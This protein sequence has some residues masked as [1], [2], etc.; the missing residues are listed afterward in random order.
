MTIQIIGSADPDRLYCAGSFSKL[1]T[2]FITLSLLSERYDLNQILDDEKFFDAICNNKAS[3][4]FLAIFQKTIGGQF[5]LH[6]IC[7]FYTGLPYTFDPSEEEI[8]NVDAGF[9]Y[10]HHSIRDEKTFL[11]HCQNLITPVYPNRCKF[12]YSEISILFLGYLIEKVYDTS[13]EILYQKYVIEKFQLKHSHFSRKRVNDVFIQDLSEYYDLASIA[14]MDHGYFCYSNG[15]YTTLRDEKILL[16]G[17]LEN[18]VFQFM[19][20]IHI[21]RAA[22][23]RLMNGLT[24]ELRMAQDDVII[25]YDGLSFSGCN[26][27][28]YSTKHKKGYLTFND[29]GDLADKTI[30]DQFGYPAFDSVTEQSQVFYKAFVARYDFS[31]ELNKDIP[32]EFQ[33]DY[34]RVRI[35][36]I[37]LQEIFPLTRNTII[38]RDS[39]DIIYPIVS[40]DNSYRIKGKENIHGAKIG[41]YQAKSG[42]K[43][44]SSGGVLLKKITNQG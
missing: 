19:T 27:W 38:I 23:N 8:E 40:V 34:Q 44:V 43:Y 36:D 37:L 32:L 29:N 9:P 33:G 39:N 21:A 20:N 15:F 5:T 16:E 3:K 11:Y 7:S 2:T 35:N 22:S 25:G 18:S 17:L 12:H 13:F 4:D 42:N 28:A 31:M 30:F 24:V 14:I 41:L 26:L 1:L 6:D 10:K